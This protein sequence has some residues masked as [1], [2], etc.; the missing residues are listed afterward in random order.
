MIPPDAVQWHDKREEGWAYIYLLKKLGDPL[1]DQVIVK[2]NPSL[3]NKPAPVIIPES[4][5]SKK[6]E[7]YPW[8]TP[9]F[10]SSFLGVTQIETQRESTEQRL[11]VYIEHISRKWIN[12]F[13]NEEVW[14]DSS[15]KR[16]KAPLFE[17]DWCSH[18][19]YLNKPGERLG[20]EC[21]YCG[22]D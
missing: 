20:F 11:G 3:K 1:W 10:D 9:L 22:S 16:W 8:F 4:T 14:K 21:S 18:C 19:G 15:R 6:L 5:V 12:R 2:V 17:G 7:T 13:T